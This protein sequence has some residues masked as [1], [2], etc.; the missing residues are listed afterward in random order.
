MQINLLK[1][2]Q[3]VEK[4]MPCTLNKLGMW[5]IVCSAF[6]AATLAGAGT[7]LIV[8][9][10][11]LRSAILAEI[12]AAAGFLTCAYLLMKLRGSI[13]VPLRSGHIRVLLEQTASEETLERKVQIQHANQTVKDYFNSV[14]DLA[15]LERNIRKVLRKIYVSRLNIDRY[16]FDKAYVKKV[17]H[18]IT[19]ILVAFIAEAVLAYAIAAKAENAT[20]ACKT[21]L[22]IFVR[23]IERFSKSIC[24][25]NTF[26]YA[27]WIF[28]I[29]VMLFPI[30][31]LTGM[32]PFSFGLWNLVFA[33]VFAW[34]IKAAIL[35]SIAV[36]AF[37][38]LFFES[39]KDQ[40]SDP[41][42][43]KQISVLTDDF[44]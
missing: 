23:E 40:Q 42:T 16:A 27:G 39:I 13:F 8:Y 22:A 9:A 5:F 26:M 33:M 29:F 17:L 30:N 41:E 14:A 36:A 11:G 18:T 32:L 15:T 2:T 6:L 35:E 7:G 4:T 12:L 37:I 1:A 28:F 43:A 20:A 31:W 21:A 19:G 44:F 24:Y 38:P 10:F 34:G 3:L 25:L